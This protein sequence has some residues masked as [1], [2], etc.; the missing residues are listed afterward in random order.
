[1]ARAKIEIDVERCKGC[2]FCVEFCP[3]NLI[4]LNFDFNKMGYHPAVFKE[5]REGR[6][7]TGCGICALVCPDTA[8]TVYKEQKRKA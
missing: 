6:S 7:C 4:Y 2:G 3:R 1:M 8:I 5:K